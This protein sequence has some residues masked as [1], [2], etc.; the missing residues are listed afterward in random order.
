MLFSAWESVGRWSGLELFRVAGADT[1]VYLNPV[2]FQ[3]GLVPFLL[4]R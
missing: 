3:G 2:R 1:Y 4:V